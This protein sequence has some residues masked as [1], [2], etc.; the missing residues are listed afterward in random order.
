V[1]RDFLRDAS[2]YRV[3]TGVRNF[4]SI[5]KSIKCS[6]GNSILG[7]Y[8]EIVIKNYSMIYIYIYIYIHLVDARD[9]LLLV[10]VNDQLVLPAIGIILVYAGVQVHITLVYKRMLFSIIL[11]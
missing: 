7:K 1:T 10:N 8:N 5:T 9:R 11:N 2:T 4:F 6:I 3:L